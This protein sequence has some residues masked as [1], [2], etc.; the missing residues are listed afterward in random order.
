MSFKSFNFNNKSHENIK[1]NNYSDRLIESYVSLSE[2]KNHPEISSAIKSDK[3][4][5]FGL[6]SKLKPKLTDTKGIHNESKLKLINRIN[7]FRK[8]YFDYYRNHGFSLK[9]IKALKKEN[10]FFSKN[11]KKMKEK[12]NENKKQY[13]AELKEEY[14]KNNYYV[15]AFIGNKKNLFK[16]NILLSNDKELENFILYNFASN[17]SN[18]KSLSFLEKIQNEV[19]NRRNIKEGRPVFVLSNNPIY[20]PKYN[21]DKIM[22]DQKRE[23]K[24]SKSEIKKVKNTISLIDDIDFFF[25]SDNRQYL[26][27]LKYEDTRESS[28][29]I[30]TRVNSAMGIFENNQFDYINKISNLIK[31]NN[32]NNKKIEN[33]YSENT[34]STNNA[35]TTESNIIPLKIDKSVPI[36][37]DFKNI[38]PYTERNKNIKN[39]NLKKFIIKKNTLEKNENSGKIKL[40]MRI[41]S[42]KYNKENILSKLYEKINKNEKINSLKLN[43]QLKK[44]IKSYKK[45][46]SFEAEKDINSYNISNKVDNIRQSFNENISIKNDIYLRKISGSSLDKI[47][48]INKRDI[49]LK[50]NINNIEDKM[51]KIYCDLDNPKNINS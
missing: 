50:E 38:E 21:F 6:L 22:R 44:Y 39:G 16:G 12:N 45:S 40:K 25:N 37:S 27:K 2:R 48:N 8:I 5:R 43:N 18:M 35:N 26:N 31:S 42:K 24:K 14:E 3:K 49:K 19:I 13:F 36:L 34:N 29:K 51:I 32:S 1:N 30:S 33:F 41:N 17:K 10:N 47:N 28:T 46:F 7:S 11:Y 9:E 4:L 20:T 23:I 15:P